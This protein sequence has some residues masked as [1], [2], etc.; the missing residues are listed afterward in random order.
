MLSLRELV[1]ET[2]EHVCPTEQIQ[3]SIK[4]GQPSYTCPRGSA[5]RMHWNEKDTEHYRMFFH[6][7]TKLIETFRVLYPQQFH[8]EGNRAIRFR[9]V[10]EI[11]RECLGHL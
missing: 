8:Y 3:E 2:A 6:C 10:A 5:V 7:Q 9:L 4:W 1:F 11:D